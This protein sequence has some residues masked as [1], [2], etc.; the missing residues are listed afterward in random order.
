MGDISIFA[1]AFTLAHEYG[2]P[3]TIH[4][5]EVPKT[6]TVDELKMLLDYKPQ[7]IGHVINVP[8]ELKPRIERM[9]LGLELCLSCNVHAKMITGTYGDHHFGEWWGRGGKVVLCV[10][11]LF[12]LFSFSWSNLLLP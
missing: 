4:F 5:G 6:P 12:L 8:E 9:G 3:I 10:C 2:L 1:P 7:R 11:F